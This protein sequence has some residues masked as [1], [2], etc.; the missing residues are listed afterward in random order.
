MGDKVVDTLRAL[1]GW[2]CGHANARSPTPQQLIDM[3]VGA[4]ERLDPHPQASSPI[5]LAPPTNP[6]REQAM[7]LHVV[8]LITIY[9]DHYGVDEEGIK[10]LITW[11]HRAGLETIREVKRLEH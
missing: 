5:W 9:R 4:I 10:R 3:C 11:L 1:L 7:N 8:Q 2:C 6:D